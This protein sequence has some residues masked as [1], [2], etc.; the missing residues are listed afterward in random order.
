[1]ASFNPSMPMMAHPYGPA[2]PISTA[3]RTLY[4]GN[5]DKDIDKQKLFD[6]FT[7]FSK[8]DTIDRV[9]IKKDF[10][11][12]SKGFAFITFNNPNDAARAKNVFNH[13]KIKE[14]QITVSFMRRL[15]DLD[16][17][18]NLFFKNLPSQT[19]AKELEDLCTPYGNIVCCK[20]KFDSFGQSLGYG[21][22]QFEKEQAA[23]DCR[24]ALNGKL[25]HDKAVSVENFVSSKNRGSVNQKCNVYVKE[26]PGSWN[27]KQVHDFI[28]KEFAKFG[29]ITSKAV[30][31]DAKVGKPYAFVAYGTPEEAKL[32]INALNGFEFQGESVRLFVDFAQS[33]DQRRKLL[34]EK[35]AQTKNETNL[36]IKS[37]SADV[38]EDKLKRAF[39][40]FGPVTSVCVRSHE[41]AKTGPSGNP[42]KK[43]LK[44]GFVNFQQPS[45]ATDAL[46]KGKADVDV[47]ELIDP[48]HYSNVDFLYYAQPKSVRTQYLRMNMKTKK[49]AA[50]FQRQMK[51]FEAMLGQMGMQRGNYN[52][53]FGGKKQYDGQRSRLHLT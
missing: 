19:N 4:V 31:S 45:H 35:H 23:N 7:A 16:P 5:L 46:T 20:L 12:E 39:E 9:D 27:E 8:H 33:K 1:M 10:T 49:N 41:L 25:I 32:A 14:N 53:N 6:Y 2:G 38:T 17:K 18:A 44:F 42:E 29:K 37:L 3:N 48:S 28:D 24:D 13:S 50:N 43:V 11:G 47:K 40:K 30:A 51:M 21:Y 22:V 34:R 52:K 26:F 15:T 36:F